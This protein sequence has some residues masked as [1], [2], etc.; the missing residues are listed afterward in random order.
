MSETSTA[1]AAIR[2]STA[3]AFG[4]DVVAAAQMYRIPVLV[5]LLCALAWP[6]LA[7]FIAR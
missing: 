1:A 6:A 4:A 3:D 7:R 5:V 2:W